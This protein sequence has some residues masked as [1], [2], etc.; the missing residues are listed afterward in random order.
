LLVPT[1]VF[2]ALD[3]V[4]LNKVLRIYTKYGLLLFVPLAFIMSKGAYG[5]YLSLIVLL[6]L[7]VPYFKLRWKFLFVSL[8]VLC[9]FA[10]L[11]TR[12]SVIKYGMCLLILPVYSLINKVPRISLE[13]LRK[14]LFV[15]PLFLF[16][17]GVTGQFN[18]F[19]MD[20]YLGDGNGTMTTSSGENLKEDTRTGLY[21]EVLQTAQKYNTW[22]LGRTPARGNETE[23][24]SDL[25]LITGRT[26]RLAN[27][28]GVL[29][30]FTWTGLVGVFLYQMCFYRASWLALN[31]SSNRYMKW[32]GLIVAMR[33][34]YSWV[35]DITMMHIGFVT[36]WLMIG[37]C[38]SDRLRAMTDEMIGD[39]FRSILMPEEPLENAS[40]I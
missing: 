28:V 27:E 35:E 30:I 12:S 24:F 8:G 29:N 10:D 16:F 13:I 5:F 26:E 33:W 18:V 39:W 14:L 19:R 32:L 31:R 6:L 21:V 37:M 15:L 40:V 11:G 22:W 9:T 1:A 34:C 25:A 38:Y 20:D 7:A 36:L 3:T 23:L 2:V 4:T 17:L